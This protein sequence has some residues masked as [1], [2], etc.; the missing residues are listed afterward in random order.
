MPLNVGILS[1][2]TYLPP[3][4]R[5]NEWWPDDTVARWGENAPRGE[6]RTE[7]G[8]LTREQALVLS[9]QSPTLGD[10]FR[11]AKE[12]RVLAPEMSSLDMEVRAARDALDQA[13]DSA[14]EID[15][16]LS[17]S[18]VPDDLG[19]NTAALLHR[20]LELSPSCYSLSVEGAHNSLLLQLAIAESMIRVGR[21]TKALLVQS[22][23]ASRILPYD[24]P[25]STQFG[26]GATAVVVGAVSGDRGV[27]ATA[28]RTDGSRAKALV[29]G[30]PG[31][32]WYEDGRCVIY[33]RDLATA[34]GLL[35]DSASMAKEVLGEALS[36]SAVPPDSV[37][38]FAC[39]QPTVWFRQA[40]QRAAGLTNARSADTYA[41]LGSLFACNLPL[42]LSTG[43]AA[44]TLRDGDLVALFS[45]GNGATFSATVMR[46]GR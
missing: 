19:T 24:E 15:L 8:A 13:G 40:A 46:W 35:L 5:T 9:A 29:T 23:A 20:K 34:H 45:G 12:R 27:L 43:A 4:I 25:Y 41:T 11:G 1:I 36:T 31:S 14:R 37:D 39:H 7:A 2:G 6:A 16:L 38:F 30:I 10:P 17:Y 33:S 42:I 32:E 44:G 3:H 22:C 21:A 28:H 18:L 26:D